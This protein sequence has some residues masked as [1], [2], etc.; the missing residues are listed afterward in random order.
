MGASS[1]TTFRDSTYVNNICSVSTPNPLGFSLYLPYIPGLTQP[2]QGLTTTAPGSSYQIISRDAFATTKW[3]I[4]Y[5]GT[6]VDRLPA[7]INVQSPLFMIGLDKNSIVV[8]IS[9]YALGLNSPLSSIGQMRLSQ[10]GT[11]DAINTF[12]AEQVKRGQFF[13]DTHFRPNSAYRLRTRVPF[14]FFAPLQSE[15]GDAFAFGSNIGGEYGMGY[16]YSQTT[17]FVNINGIPFVLSADQTFGI[18]DKI[19]FNDEH[20]RVSWNG[21]SFIASSQAALSAHGASKALFVLGSN[22]Y[23]QLG[24]GSTQ[25]YYPTWTRVPG[26]WKDIDMGTQHMVAINSTGHLYACGSNASGQLGLGSGFASV[27]ALTLVDNT[28]N[29]VQL[30]TT[31]YSTSVRDANGAIYSCGKNDRGQLGINSTTTPVYT[32]TREATNSTWTSIKTIKTDTFVSLIALKNNELYGCGIS[33]VYWGGSDF[34]QRNFFSREALS[35]TD[36]TDFYTTAKGT[37]IRRQGQDRLFASGQ[38]LLAT[39]SSGYYFIET[40]IPSDIRNIFTYRDFTNT[41]PT[42]HLGYIGSDFLV[43]AKS[44][45]NNTFFQKQFNA[46]DSF[47]SASNSGV[48]PVFLLS[49]ASHFRPTPTPTP[50]RTPIPTP[51]RTPIPTPTVTPTTSRTTFDP[52]NVLQVGIFGSNYPSN[53]STTSQQNFAYN[54]PGNLN[55]VFTLSNPNAGSIPPG[56]ILSSTFD[57]EKGSFNNIVGI[58]VNV[59][60][61]QQTAGRYSPRYIYKKIGSNW[62]YTLLPADMDAML[63]GVEQYSYKHGCDTLLI[64]PEHPGYSNTSQGVYNLIFVRDKKFNEAVSYDRGVNWTI[65]EFRTQLNEYNDNAGINKVLYSR[66]RGSNYTVCA[67]MVASNG[68]QIFFAQRFPDFNSPGLA[69]HTSS[70]IQGFNFTHDYKNIPT[71]VFSTIDSNATGAIYI[72]RRINGSWQSVAVK[73]NIAY[74]SIG[75]NVL[76]PADLGRINSPTL[77]LE[78]DPTNSNLIYIAYL[79]S[80]GFSPNFNEAVYINVLCY[81]MATNSVVFDESVVRATRASGSVPPSIH[82]VD[83]LVADVP[84][85]FYD[86]TNNSLNLFFVGQAAATPF[87]ITNYIMS[88]NNVNGSWSAPTS[89][90]TGT[91]LSNNNELRI[92]Y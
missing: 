34:A 80:A 79:R 74:M 64:T 87:T 21:Q 70:G 54:S 46:F 9:S 29:Y 17:R 44:L 65:R 85:L 92:K 88:R 2:N 39:L 67:V 52:Y 30:A 18:W 69:I 27:N 68:S 35:L 28:R 91:R 25:Q 82:T 50:T 22:L 4:T 89:F 63:T 40:T 15:M 61:A 48:S 38:S 86:K 60:S 10:N 5:A 36:I 49:A 12:Y 78:V 55:N 19:V 53:R 13:G 83:S 31:G 56:K 76:Y 24:T 71:V 20:Q 58:G 33:E 84:T 7:A 8:P 72:T 32:F 16:R 41:D 66:S 1:S 51:T 77:G 62:T 3:S 73:Q 81:N 45:N 6:D 59:S 47:S 11:Y 37:L 43:Y 75:P 26:Q 42:P 57:Y 14:T 23:G 90:T